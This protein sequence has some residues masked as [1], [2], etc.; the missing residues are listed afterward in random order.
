MEVSHNQIDK[1]NF[2]QRGREKNFLDHPPIEPSPR[3]DSIRVAQLASNY[4]LSTA[5]STMPTQTFPL[6]LPLFLLLL[7]FQLSFACN[8]NGACEPEK[9]ET[10]S[11]CAH[12][13]CKTA[14]CDCQDNDCNHPKAPEHAGIG[15]VHNRKHK[16][17]RYHG[18][19]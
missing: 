12:D 19:I 15:H 9:G 1:F 10:W 17:Y 8:G 2:C 7:L 5:I 14:D 4:E 3:N 18:D 16:V 13:C 11:N 6:L